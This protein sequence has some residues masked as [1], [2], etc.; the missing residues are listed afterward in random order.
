VSVGC[1]RHVSK[2]VGRGAQSGSGRSDGVGLRQWKSPGSI[3]STWFPATNRM[4][5]E[6]ALTSGNR[7][8]APTRHGA[9]I[10]PRDDRPYRAIDV[11][12]SARRH[13]SEPP[14]GAENVVDQSR[15]ADLNPSPSATTSATTRPRKSSEQKLRAWRFRLSPCFY[16][17]F[18][19]GREDLNLRPPE[20]HS[21]GP[22]ISPSFKMR[23]VLQ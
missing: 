6:S 21:R 8:S 11:L 3:A 7:R 22:S 12:K 2:V 1:T 23:Q 9:Q 15:A 19:S 4:S 20:P 17:S 5:G 18:W 10:P 13:A 14:R 16:L